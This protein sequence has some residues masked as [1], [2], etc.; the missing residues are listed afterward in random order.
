MTKTKHEVMAALGK[1]GVPTGAV[2]D[3]GRDHGGPAPQGA[4]DDQHDPAP[5]LGR[6][7]DARQPGAAVEVA[8]GDRPAPLL[9]QH[10]AEIYKEWLSLGAEDLT[11]LKTDGVV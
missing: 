10:N 4:E 6:V 5:G 11:K 2:P 1:A 7:H 9:G 8:D 3:A